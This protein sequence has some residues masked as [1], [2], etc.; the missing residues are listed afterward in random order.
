MD[1]DCLFAA[2]LNS[3]CWLRWFLDTKISRVHLLCL[4]RTYWNNTTWLVTWNIFYDFPFRWECHHPD[5]ECHVFFFQTGRS[6][7][8]QL[9]WF[10]LQ[11]DYS[12]A[13]KNCQKSSLSSREI[14]GVHPIPVLLGQDGAKKSM[15]CECWFL[16]PIEI[17]LFKPIIHGIV[18]RYG[19]FI[20]YYNYS[21]ISY[22]NIDTPTCYYI[23]LHQLS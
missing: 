19:I 12:W 22:L 8:N 20:W 6:T 18:V 10:C 3:N 13:S 15:W 4:I 16:S 7:T 11:I 23:Y 1:F 17:Y 9:L 14:Q 5:W 2:A 21:Y